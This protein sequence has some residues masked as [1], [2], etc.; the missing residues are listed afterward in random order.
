MPHR[1]ITVANEFV[2]QFG[3]ANDIDHLKLQ[4]LT[5][6]TQGWWLA[7][8]GEEL[9][10]ERPQVWRYGPVFQSMYRILAGKGR[11]PIRVPVVSNPFAHF[12]QVEPDTLE[13]PAHE[14]KR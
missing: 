14:D 10:F 1:P 12:G 9:L 6:F 5:Y 8:H 2:R 11:A 7:G 13:A 4:K 3:G